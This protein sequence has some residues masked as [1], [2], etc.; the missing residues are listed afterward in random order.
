MYSKEKGDFMKKVSL[1]ILILA[2]GISIQGCSGA[3]T[4]KGSI[5]DDAAKHKQTEHQQ[6]KSQEKGIDTD[7]LLQTDDPNKLEETKDSNNLVNSEMIETVKSKESND[8]VELQDEY[9]HDNGD[10]EIDSLVKPDQD[11]IE[12][13]DKDS[14]KDDIK[15]DKKDLKNEEG[16][17]AKNP[18]NLEEIKKITIEIE[19]MEEEINGRT[20]KSN[21]G[22]QMIYDFDRFQVT[23][24]EDSDQFMVENP[25]P[26]RYPYVFL[27]ILRMEEDSLE[28][29]NL[30]ESLESGK[31]KVAETESYINVEQKDNLRINQ[32][33]AEQYSYIEGSDWDSLVKKYYL[34]SM[35]KSLYLIESQY[36]LGAAEG[37]GARILAMLDTFTI[38]N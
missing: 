35:D 18:E 25:D 36:F 19:G 13:D 6:E 29:K 3:V 34:L 21:L 14:E 37:F 22:Y 9:L 16:E 4:N 2:A 38:T 8:S 17:D 24:F 27:R 31:I 26:S 1:V 10:M 11:D 28:A 7:N 12:E 30:R 20:F 23:S 33:E 32:W 5:E 15:S